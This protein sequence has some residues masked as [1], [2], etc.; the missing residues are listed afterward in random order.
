MISIP[1]K[2]YDEQSVF[3]GEKTKNNIIENS[4]FYN[5]N[6]STETFSLNNIVIDFELNDLHIENYYNKYK[7]TIINIGKND[8]ILDNIKYIEQTILEKFS[9][10]KIKLYKL[11][12]QFN[13]NNI[14]IFSN[15]HIKTGNYDKLSLILKISGLWED[16]INCGIIYKLMLI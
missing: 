10:N 2:M 11:C 16:N 3:F 8:I 1:L 15:V 5:I 14:K 13:K 6:Y 12:D 7:C 9:S 4:Y